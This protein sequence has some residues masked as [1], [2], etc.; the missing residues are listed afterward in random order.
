MKGKKKVAKKWI[1]PEI[2]VLSPDA[3]AS[4]K[5]P[6]PEGQKVGKKPIYYKS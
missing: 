3:T 5:P 1:R 2:I 4:G 6:G